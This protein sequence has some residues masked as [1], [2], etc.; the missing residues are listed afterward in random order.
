MTEGEFDELMDYLEEIGAV[1]AYG[2]PDESGYPMYRLN[3]D[4]LKEYVPEVHEAFMQQLDDELLQLYK[5]GLVDIEYDENLEAKFKVSEKGKK[6][7]ETG[8]LPE[9][10]E[11]LL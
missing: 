2:E 8:I 10:D 6:F 1:E 7:A 5:L 9:I 3:M 11:D 4:V